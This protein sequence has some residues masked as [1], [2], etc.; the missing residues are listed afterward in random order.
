MKPDL[1]EV[2][3]DGSQVGSVKERYHLRSLSVMKHHP[4]TYLVL[5]Q[6]PRKSPLPCANPLPCAKLHKSQT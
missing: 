1:E 6:K 5:N 3:L 4:K 2:F